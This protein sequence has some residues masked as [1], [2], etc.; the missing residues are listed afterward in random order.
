MV[1]SVRAPFP[2]EFAEG[3][4]AVL[5]VGKQRQG[6]TETLARTRSIVRAHGGTG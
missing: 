5:S 3:V 6:V 2:G 1:S 4:K